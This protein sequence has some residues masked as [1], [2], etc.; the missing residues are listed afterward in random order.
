MNN[1]SKREYLK[2]LFGQEIMS[3]LV[4][5]KWLDGY[6][7]GRKN[8]DIIFWLTGLQKEKEIIYWINRK[9]SVDIKVEHINKTIVFLKTYKENCYMQTILNNF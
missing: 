2:R 1:K 9:F 5:F 8:K 7:R 3:L 4:T 6:A